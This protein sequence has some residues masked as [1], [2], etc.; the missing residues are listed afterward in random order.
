MNYVASI[1]GFSWRRVNVSVFGRRR[2]NGIG[3]YPESGSDA[4]IAVANGLHLRPRM[5]KMSLWKSLMTTMMRTVYV[6][7]IRNTSVRASCVRVP[8]STDS[9]HMLLSSKRGFCP[10][11][12]VV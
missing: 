8:N 2:F 9:A 7:R 4:R 12:G 6:D 1:C 11:D 5:R 3:S 10:P